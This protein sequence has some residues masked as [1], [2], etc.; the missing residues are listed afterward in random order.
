MADQ[1]VLKMNHISKR[2]GGTYALKDV[3]MK[4]EKGKVNVIMGE[5][6][7]GKSTLMR[8]LAGAITKDEGCS[9]AAV[10]VSSP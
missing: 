1:Y 10:S 6:G 2:F 4:F 9:R 5:N 8:I 3:S 7:A